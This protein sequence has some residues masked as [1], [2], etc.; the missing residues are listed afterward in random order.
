MAFQTLIDPKHLGIRFNKIYGFI[1][2]YDG[3]EYLVLLGPQK[4]DTIATELVVSHIMLLIIWQKS[5]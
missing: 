4:Y 2:A 3:S 1:K 5:S